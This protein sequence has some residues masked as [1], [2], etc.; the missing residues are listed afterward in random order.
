MVVVVFALFLSGY[1]SWTVSHSYLYDTSFTVDY[2]VDDVNVSE[3][4][5]VLF[6]ELVI[7]LEAPWDL[8]KSAKLNM[9]IDLLSY[10]TNLFY[11][12]GGSGMNGYLEKNVTLKSQLIAEYDSLLKSSSLNTI[13]ILHRITVSCEEIIEFCF[14][15]FNVFIEGQPCCK[16]L[17]REPEF[18]MMGKC[19]RTHGQNINLTLK[20]VGLQSG[21]GIK[22][23][24]KKDI[25]SQ[26]NHNIVN[27]PASFSDGVS[28]AAVNQQSH[29]STIISRAIG[30]MPNA[31]NNINL[32]RFTVDRSDRS[33]PF[34]TYSCI[35]DDDLKSYLRLT[36][37]YPAYTRDNCIAAQ[38][39]KLTVEHFN[40]SLI[41]FN[42]IPNT[43]YCGPDLITQ[44]YFERYFIHL[45][46]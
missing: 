7:C 30:I 45:E 5:P 19:F 11:P 31:L 17:F 25:L 36:P 26:L 29:I 21:L 33:S 40:C 43:A 13:Q 10:M 15:G 41:Y 2:S 16:L 3:S 28:L 8:A 20:D 27:Y 32:K 22:V 12:Y 37:G 18:G 46:K 38:K 9:S 39:Q 34:G 1:F 35:E 23:T 14:F 42:A 6:P 44:I 4:G 24:V